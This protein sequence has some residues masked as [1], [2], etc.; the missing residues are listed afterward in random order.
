VFNLYKNFP[1]SKTMLVPEDICLRRKFS[2]SSVFFSCLFCV[3]F[4][5]SRSS[6]T[7]AQTAKADPLSAVWASESVSGLPVRGNLVIDGRSQPWQASVAGY[8]IAVERAGSDVRF[9]LPGGKGKFRGHLMA[10]PGM[11]RGEWIQPKGDILNSEY[12]SP[13]EL[14]SIQPSVW[15]GTVVPLEQ[16]VSVYISIQ[17]TTT[18]TLTAF[19]SNPEMNFF[20]RRTYTVSRDGTKVRLTAQGEEID[21]AF[22]KE[23]DTL[24]LQ[25]V[26]FEPP[27][28]F[29]RVHDKDAAGFYPRVESGAYRYREPI[30]RKDGWPTASLAEVGLDERPVAEMI[31]RILTADPGNNPAYIQSLLIARHGRLALEEYFYG[32]DAERPHDM[33]SA[34]KTFAPAMVGAAIEHGAKL[35]PETS[36][37]SLFSRYGS[38]ENPDPRKQKMS[39]RDIMTMTAGNACDDNDDS[40][41]GNE[42]TMQQQSKESDWY[43]YTLDLPMLHEPGGEDAV[44]CSADLNLV[45]G[46]VEQ[47]TGSWLPE[48][49]DQYLAQPLQ[50]GPY[51][52]NLMPDEQAYTGGGTYL[53]PRDQIKLG[54]L[55]LNGGVWNGKRILS[56]EWVTESTSVH[57][58]FRPEY[59]L[60]QEH[61]Y[62]YGWHIHDLVSE[63]KTYR[64][65]AAEGNGGQLVIVI[66][67]LDLVIGITGG[68]YGEFNKW[69]RWELELVPQFIIPAATGSSSPISK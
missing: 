41:P 34:S 64:V 46:A 29:V 43:R 65:F 48:I 24:T 35:S 7:Q 19:I 33:R 60:G 42:D 27:F 44:Y 18:N 28:R 63:G 9:T 53:R 30:A 57:S 39:L 25:L 10:N 66:P 68:S 61:G 62:G 12:A 56:R 21:G 16:R 20:R 59:S 45:G 23:N 38:F 6:T 69:Y 58:H 1:Q 5:E 36:V 40:S 49:F 55:F 22:D 31:R 52:L 2:F 50:F 15:Q 47:A 3:V 32:F 51:Y 17:Q 8:S 14:S 4:F 11:I 67:G 13:I 26:S 37:A 54:Q